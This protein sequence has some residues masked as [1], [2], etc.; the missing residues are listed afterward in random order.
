MEQDIHKGILNIVED[1]RIEKKI[2]RKY[3]GIVR[4]FLQGYAALYE[5]RFF[6]TTPFEELGFIDRINLFFKLGS[7]SGIM[8]DST[9]QP[10]VDLVADCES[11]DDVVECSKILQMAYTEELTTSQDHGFEYNEI[12]ET[13]SGS[14]LDGPKDNN[15][16]CEDEDDETGSDI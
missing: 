13:G 4:P 9:E 2:K 15:E 12:S 16:F 1:A 3:P 7:L 14:P 6:G 8:F 10:Y 5:R 11:W